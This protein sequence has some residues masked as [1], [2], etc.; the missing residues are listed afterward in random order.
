[1]EPEK[2]CYVQI[3]NKAHL[4][5][6]QLEQDFEIWREFVQCRD[7][8]NSVLARTKF[9][10][11]P[12]EN[13]AG[14]HFNIQKLTHALNDI[15]N[16]TG[17]LDFLNEKAGEIES[18]ADAETKKKLSEQMKSTN[19]EWKDLVGSLESRRETLSVLAQHWEQFETQMQAVESNLTRC[20]EKV[21]L[22]DMVVRSR[23]QLEETKSNLLVGLL[24]RGYPSPLRTASIYKTYNLLY[25]NC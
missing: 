25:R 13:L 7:K 16:Q 20:E 11:E 2:F 17:S 18:Q 21:K 12:V 23:P 6:A 24:T 19:D 3:T 4:S 15:S 5:R 14:L 1:M 22:I 10:D 9:V 8:V